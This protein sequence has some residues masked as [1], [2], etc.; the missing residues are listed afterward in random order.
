MNTILEYLKVNT[1]KDPLGF[2]LVLLFI[3]E[4][5]TGGYFGLQQPPMPMDTLRTLSEIDGP[6]ID[7][8]GAMT[9]AV[10]EFC[11]NAVH[12]PAIWFLALIVMIVLLIGN[13]AWALTTKDRVEWVPEAGYVF[14]MIATWGF[15]DDCHTAPWFPIVLLKVSLLIFAIYLFLLERKTKPTLF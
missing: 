4:V 8:A 14:L 15:I 3:V 2:V 13:F 5:L 11:A 6:T 12:F 9:S 7:G 10:I 1:G